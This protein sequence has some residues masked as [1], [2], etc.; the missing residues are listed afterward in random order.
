MDTQKIKALILGILATFA[1]LYLGISAATAQFET[2]AWV[3]GGVTLLSCLFMGSKIWLLIP[4][5]AA[6]GI[7]LRLPGQ[8]DTLLIAQILVL[9]F[10]ALLFLMR[11]LPF[12]PAL[13]ELELWIIIITLFVVQVYIRNPVGVN[14]F[15][16]DTVGGKVYALYAIALATSVLLCGMRIPSADLKW[17]LRLGIIGGMINFFVSLSGNYIPII[18][19]YTGARFEEVGGEEGF[20]DKVVDAAVATRIPYLS[21]L[22]AN[23][24]LW[25]VSYISPL[26]ALI[27]PLWLVLMLIAL[28]AA[29]MGGFRNGVATV[30]LTLLLGIAYRSGMPGLIASL[31]G[32]G[33]GLGLLAVVNLVHPLP[34]NI[35]RSLTFLPGTWEQRYRDD[36]DGSTEWRLEIWREAILTDRWIKNK[37]LG[38]GL[39]FS[40]TELAAQMTTRKGARAGVSGFEAHRESVLASGDYHSG[41]VSTVRTIGYIGLFFFL[42]AQIRLSVHAHRQIMR[43]KGTEWLPLAMYVCVPIIFGPIFFTFIF[44]DFKRGGATFLLSLGM[45]RLLQNNLPLAPY[46]KRG[47]TP[48]MPM[49]TG[50]PAPVRTPSAGRFGKA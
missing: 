2:I 42:L 35:Q 24:S 6:V 46:M 18:G 37:W 19:Y 22:G 3:I 14:L 28:V 49:A 45:L 30:G 50:Q 47:F 34:P 23:I 48:I 13:T 15:G 20:D 36:A 40:A 25:L 38:D 17:I 21:F 44:G 12:R 27:R 7:Q 1:A 8:P 5:M 10:G 31:V 39:G 11:K 4:F 32:A 43:C 29:L 33:C 26:K 9:C 16:G 41:P